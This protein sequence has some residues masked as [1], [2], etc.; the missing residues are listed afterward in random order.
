MICLADMASMW[1]HNPYVRNWIN[2]IKNQILECTKLPNINLFLYFLSRM[3]YLSP[4]SSPFFSKTKSWNSKKNQWATW[5]LN[6]G[7]YRFVQVTYHYCSFSNELLYGLFFTS[8][9]FAGIKEKKIDGTSNLTTRSKLSST[10]L[11][12]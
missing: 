11:D 5:G 6:M 9:V 7:P 12:V 1:L 2:Y 4:L 8:T 3:I 10:F